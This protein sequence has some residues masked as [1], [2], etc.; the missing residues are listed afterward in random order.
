MD[1]VPG[2]SGVVLSAWLR[3]RDLGWR[4]GVHVAARDPFRGYAS[5]LRA[6][7][8]HALRVLDA[9][10]VVRCGFDAVDQVRRRVQ[11]ET[12][13]H[14][15]HDHHSNTSWAWLLAGLAVGDPDGEVAA[16][17]IAA[18]ELR[19]LYRH[20]TPPAPRRRSAGLAFCADSEVPELHR[21]ARSL[22]SWREELL[23][24][25]TVARVFKRPTGAVNPADQ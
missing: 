15:G 3:E 9:F 16:A 23:A 5:A 20:H 12:L 25:F 8:P 19:L 14:R 4:G 11:Q 1:I 13:G 10:H 24:R 6:Q 17:W 2:R 18:H 7:L 22:D 21:L